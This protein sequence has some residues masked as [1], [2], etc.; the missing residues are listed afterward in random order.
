M[1]GFPLSWIRKE[2]LK[3]WSEGFADDAS[4]HS[5]Q[6]LLEEMVGLGILRTTTA[7]QCTLRSPNVV[8]LMGTRDDIENAPVRAR[9]APPD[10]EAATFR[11][12]LRKPSGM[13]DSIRRN[14]LTDRQES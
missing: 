10:Y 4:E 12:A 8:S 7:D 13:I 6:V 1:K 3:Y 2:V 11:S 5:F 14:P 9:E